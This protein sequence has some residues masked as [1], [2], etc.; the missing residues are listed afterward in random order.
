MNLNLVEVGREKVA[1]VIAEGVVIG[2]VQDALDLLATAQFVEGATCLMLEQ[3]NLLPEFFE[4][5]TGI[6]GEILQKYTNYR[7]KLLIVGD[8]AHIQSKSLKA[9][10]LE[11]N[12]GKQVAFMPDRE[13]A[14][15]HIAAW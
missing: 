15:A 1:E 12:R 3:K 9:F 2:S 6:A 11:S 7:M 13:A 4:L 10:M 5:K 8:F 14:L